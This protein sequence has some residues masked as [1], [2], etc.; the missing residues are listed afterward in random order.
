MTI[1]RIDEI[2]N[3]MNELKLELEVARYETTN[4]A[5]AA[6]AMAA[7]MSCTQV[8]THLEHMLANKESF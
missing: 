3:T 8:F 6:H 2:Q 7:E 4:D 1:K 5:E